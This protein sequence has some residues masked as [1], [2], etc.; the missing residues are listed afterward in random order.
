MIYITYIL[1]IY[2]Y[3]DIYDSNVNARGKVE[4]HARKV[5]ITGVEMEVP[6]LMYSVHGLETRR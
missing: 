3:I 2:I 4:G 6:Y 5:D 1:H